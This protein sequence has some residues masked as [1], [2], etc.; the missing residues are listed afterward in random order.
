MALEIKSLGETPDPLRLIVY[1]AP[2]VGKTT[3]AAS[4]P[5]PI[6]LD[7]E[8]STTVLRGTSLE[9]VPVI[10]DRKTLSDYD[11]VL[12]FIRSDHGY[13]TIIIDSV[14]A[15]YDAYLMTHMK[16]KKKGDRHIALFADFRKVVNVLKEVFYALIDAPCHVILIAHEKYRVD[17]E[18]QRILEIRPQLPPS[19]EAAIERLVN[20]VFYMETKPALRGAAERILWVDSQG[21]ILAKNRQAALTE[22]SYTN[23]TMK[24]IYPNV[25]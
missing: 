24:E 2:G 18:S 25:R 21:K 8:N 3:W 7:Y 10:N 1:G 13:G 12:R 15:M 11:Q 4:A 17:N 23:T 9:D 14:S 6:F 16:G 19:A 5:N 20:E 22:S